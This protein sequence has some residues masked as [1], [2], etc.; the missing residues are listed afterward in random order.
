MLKKLLLMTFAA[1]TVFSVNA[2]SGGKF[3]MPKT[4]KLSRTELLNKIKGGWA[5]QTIGVTYG[6]P[7]E[8]RYQSRMI[9]D[10][11]AIK[12]SD[13]YIAETME[14][15]P[16]LY[17]DVYMDLTFVGLFD[18]LG[19]DA[20]VDSMAK[21]FAYA[22]YSLWHANQAARYNIKHGIMPPLSG[23]WK[24]NPHADCID[25]QIEADF[26]GLMSPGM[27]NTASEISDGIGHI[28]N[29]GDG[30]YGGIFMG[31][32]YSIAFVTD[33]IETIVCEALKAIPENT[34]FRLCQEDVITTWRQ[35]PDDWKTAWHM[36]DK[37]WNSDDIG[38]PEGALAPL[39][40]DAT[41][42]SAYVIIGLLY[43][44]GDLGKT[45]EISTRCGQ[46]SDCNP[47][48]A[49]GILCTAKGY[50]WIPDC[51]LNTLKKA[52]DIKFKYTDLSLKRIYEMSFSQALDVIKANGGKVTDKAVTIRCQT[53]K[54]VRREVSFEGINA[55]SR[56]ELGRKLAMPSVGIIDTDFTFSAVCDGIAVE[57]YCE[58][59]NQNY[60]AVLS[61]EI[62]GQPAGTIELPVRYR[63]RKYEIYWNYDLPAN[64]WKSNRHTF[65]FK[66]LNPMSNATI[67]FKDA[68][69]YSKTDLK[70]PF[71]SE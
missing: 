5:G 6:G 24:N 2:V 65:E 32:M 14:S 11:I 57:G 51:W 58:S 59:R 62:D 3:K 29:Y 63:D 48:S 42:N 27:P 38:C 35:H 47:A 33:D 44:N 54:P 21:A 17:D 53:P 43:G 70:R 55:V 22:D 61:L 1:L 26:A 66:W 7:T 9:D 34:R 49:A 64:L 20:P 18:K 15:F 36:L 45:M 19:I 41:M 68:I 31:A 52:E 67:T 13:N 12:W 23:F 71:L 50:D 69:L 25:Y 16:E 8:F 30:W 60:V 4:L 28:M 10:S 37:K 46:D 40:I 39:N 56:M